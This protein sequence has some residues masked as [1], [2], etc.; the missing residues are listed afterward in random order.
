MS[1]AFRISIAQINTTVGDLAGNRDRIL[2]AIRQAR[3]AGAQLVTFPELALTGYPPEDLLFQEK[4]VTDNL[5]ALRMLLPHTRG[6]SAVVGFVDRD[7]RGHLYNAAALL[8]DGR[9]AAVYHKMKLPNYGVFDEQR[10]FAAGRQGLTVK[11]GGLRVGF[12]ICEDIWQKDAAVYRRGY[13]G[14]ADLLVNISASPYHAGKQKEREALLKHLAVRTRAAVVY[15]NLVGG[16]D[17]LVFDGGSMVVTAK[18][19]LA[20]EAHRFREDLLTIDI[21]VPPGRAGAIRGRRERSLGREEEIYEALVLGTRDY[22]RKNGFKKVLIGLSGGIDSALVAQIAVDALGSDNVIGVTMPS[23]YTSAA[24][25]RDAKVLA[26]S[27]GVQCLEIT[28]GKIFA[29]YLRIF[30]G[31]FKGMPA[32]TTEENVQA[33]IRGTLLMALSN[34]LGHLVLTTGNKSETATG[35]CTLYGDMAGGFAVI[36]DVPK[37]LVYALCR[38]RNALSPKGAVPASILKRAPT[39]ELRPGQKDSDSLPRYAVLDRFLEDYIEKDLSIKEILRK[40]FSPPLARRLARLVDRNE[41]K[42]RQAPPGVK[43]TPK[44]FGRDRRM[45]ITNRYSL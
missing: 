8:T 37:T 45:P 40:G 11:L 12:T 43:I 19:L 7:V 38:Y 32:D 2:G 15:H 36:K 23:P 13:S 5:N 24:T 22:V 3:R 29:A 17:E 16:Q 20:A 18:G 25:L 35:Y 34:K 26:K 31:L 1:G 21:P 28:I 10:Y 14:S 27:L 42:R 33:R 4:F 44:A 6:L 30:R 9:L 41:Y 39:A